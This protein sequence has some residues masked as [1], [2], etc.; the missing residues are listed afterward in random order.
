MADR[1]LDCE[2]DD[3]GVELT[4]EKDVQPADR[5][6]W[7]NGLLRWQYIIPRAVLT[8]LVWAFFA[9][10]FDPLL[11]V[12]LETG[13]ESVVGAEVDVQ[14]VQTR[15]FPPEFQLRNVGVADPRRTDENAVTFEELVVRMAGEPL[16]HREYVVREAVVKGV[17]FNVDRMTDGS[18]EEGSD[19]EGMDFGPLQ[20]Q[21]KRLGLRWYDELEAVAR[22]QLDPQSLETVQ[23]AESIESEWKLRFDDLETRLDR[24]QKRI[25]SVEQL[26][27]ADGDA[28]EKLNA[29]TRVADEV[30]SILQESQR[31]RDEVRNL[32]GVARVDAARID[33]ARR[34][35][36]A[37]LQQRIQSPP[38]TPE[39]ISESLLGPELAARLSSLNRWV[40][41]MRRYFSADALSPP[42][43]PRRGEWIEF[44]RAEVHPT[45]VLESLTLSGEATKDGQPFGIRGRCRHVSSDPPLYGRPTEWTLEMAGPDPLAISGRS[46]LTGDT[47]LHEVVFDWK[48]DRQLRQLIGDGDKLAI[49]VSADSARCEGWLR[50]RGGELEGRVRLRQAPL[51]VAVSESS[52][53]FAKRWIAPA[54]SSVK[55]ADTTLHLSGDLDHLD[56][57]VESDLGPQVSRGLSQLVTNEVETQRARLMTKVDTVAQEQLSTIQAL[58]DDK[59]Q[60]LLTDLVSGENQAK[61]AVSKLTDDKLDVRKLS[62]KLNFDRFLRR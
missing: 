62:D 12:G 9:W 35:D 24:L 44:P 14:Q 17:R 61:L 57:Q 56:W 6:S 34:R 27:K 38:I 1:S 54:F 45:F 30:R 32:P 43:A 47:A 10:G 20:E 50:L 31:L 29:Y 42:P 26:A 51:D 8:G 2:P 19:G 28:V 7:F 40:G 25:D 18:L 59:T 36:L 16:L 49:A 58:V 3:G 53:E 23:V 52:D 55:S 41:W 22:K 21:M 37:R 33:Q 5:R 4:D 39:Q 48:T 11:R 46:D 15:F 13:A 60:G